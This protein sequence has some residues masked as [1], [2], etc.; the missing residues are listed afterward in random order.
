MSAI[1]D[2][3]WMEREI[4]AMKSYSAPDMT[5]LVQRT[6]TQP[7]TTSQDRKTVSIRWIDNT[8]HM[9]WAMPSGVQYLVL[10]TIRDDGLAIYTYLPKPGENV[11]LI[12]NSFD[13]F[14]VVG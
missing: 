12:F 7:A 14:R 2:I 5:L 11:T 4:A 13:D 9:I 1:D 10:T 8:R 6:Y 3:A